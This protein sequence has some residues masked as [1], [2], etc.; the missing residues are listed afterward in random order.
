MKKYKNVSVVL[1]NISSRKCCLLGTYVT[2]E[3]NVICKVQ[4]YCS[5]PHGHLLSYGI[6]K[7]L[8]EEISSSVEALLWALFHLKGVRII[9]KNKIKSVH[10][11]KVISQIARLFGYT[12]DWYRSDVTDVGLI[13]TRYQYKLSC[14]LGSYH[15][16]DF[17]E[18]TVRTMFNIKHYNFAY[19]CTILQYHT[20]L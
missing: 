6:R 2:V 5:K 7:I 20:K 15:I 1:I 9:G 8:W 3:A 19:T 18:L 13:W 11:V 12:D 17:F 14:K 16:Q 10:S 4:C